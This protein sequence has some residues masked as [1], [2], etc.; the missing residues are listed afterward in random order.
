LND[1]VAGLVDQGWP[2]LHPATIL[3]QVQLVHSRFLAWRSD[4]RAVARSKGN[5]TTI[6]H[7]FGW[8]V[9]QASYVHS[10]LA[11]NHSHVSPPLPVSSA[12]L[13]AVGGAAEVVV[14]T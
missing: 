6:D 12:S 3:N 7:V 4:S 1:V 11:T 14:V 8:V 5:L 10:L 2:P 9:D 13:S